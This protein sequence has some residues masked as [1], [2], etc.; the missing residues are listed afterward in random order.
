MFV[1]G[2]AVLQAPHLVLPDAHPYDMCAAAP[3]GRVSE[4]A[5]LVGRRATRHRL[6]RD[7]SFMVPSCHRAV[8]VSTSVL[9]QR[10]CAVLVAPLVVARAMTS[11]TISHATFKTVVECARPKRFTHLPDRSFVVRFSWAAGATHAA[12]WVAILPLRSASRDVR[13]GQT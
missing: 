9:G 8:A 3:I 4:I 6:I 5:M 11:T 7:A 12:V 1:G 10:I 2:A 13:P